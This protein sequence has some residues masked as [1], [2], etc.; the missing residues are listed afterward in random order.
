MLLLLIAKYTRVVQNVLSLKCKIFR[1]TLMNIVGFPV[2]VDM[3]DNEISAVS[4]GIP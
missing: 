3:R 1:N 2:H 4:I